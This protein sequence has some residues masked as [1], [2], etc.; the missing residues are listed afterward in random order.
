MQN[1]NQGMPPNN[2]QMNQNNSGGGFMQQNQRAPNQWMP[3]NNSG[4][5]GVL[6]DEW[7]MAEK[8][9]MIALLSGEA[10]GMLFLLEQH[11]PTGTWAQPFP[12]WVH[13]FRTNQ[14]QMVTS[15]S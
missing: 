3:E 14:N 5:G 10:R 1:Y 9:A 4:G 12:L 7:E 13:S 8:F 2:S 11:D 15:C 6:K